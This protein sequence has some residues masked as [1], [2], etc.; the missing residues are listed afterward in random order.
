MSALA[1]IK[2][3]AGLDEASQCGQ[4]VQEDLRFAD[5]LV[6]NAVKSGSWARNSAWIDKFW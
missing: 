4:V 1:K 2:A 3:A 5:E 6:A